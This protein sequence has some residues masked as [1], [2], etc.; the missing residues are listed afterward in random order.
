MPVVVYSVLRVAL[1]V[2]SWL[3]LTWAGLHP[4]AALAVATFVAWG[5]SYAALGGPRDAAARYLADR[6][7]VRAAHAGRP[8]L[9]THA[10]EDADVEDAAVDA[11]LGSAVAQSGGTDDEAADGE[12]AHDGA[13]RDDAADEP[14][15]HDDE[16]ADDQAAYQARG[17]DLRERTAD[18][19][20]PAGT[21]QS[22]SASPSSIP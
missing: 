6:A 22:A 19:E 10:R 5:L 20:P 4:I 21:A 15:T 3:L 16:A 8:V 7:A 11:A 1:L 17:Q 18:G 14:V 13:A 9:S 12:V 2:V